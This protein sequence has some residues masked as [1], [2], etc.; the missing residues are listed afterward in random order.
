MTISVFSLLGERVS[1]DGLLANFETPTHFVSYPGE[2]NASFSV[3]CNVLLCLLR[4]EDVSLF[5]GQV[6]KAAS[7][8]AQLWYDSEVKDKWVSHIF[9]YFH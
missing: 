4:R 2:R 7:F 3:N 1:V 8:L 9:S 6:V 5:T